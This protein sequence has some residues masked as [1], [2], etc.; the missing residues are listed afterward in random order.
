MVPVIASEPGMSDLYLG[1]LNPQGG[2]GRLGL[3]PF[4]FGLQRALTFSHYD[5]LIR[6]FAGA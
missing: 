3:L 1:A 6:Q 2:F 4:T 5:S